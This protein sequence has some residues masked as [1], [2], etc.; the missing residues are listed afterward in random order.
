MVFMINKRTSLSFLLAFLSLISINGM[1]K[2][3]GQVSNLSNS[4]FSI[5]MYICLVVFFNFQ[6]KLTKT[7]HMSVIS[8]VFAF[9][10]SFFMISGTNIMSFD[11]TLLNDWKQWIKIIFGIPI[12]S[13]LLN[14]LFLWLIP[15]L[16]KVKMSARVES[17]LVKLFNIKYRFVFFWI[18]IFIAWVPGLI[19]SYPGI[20]G[21]DSVYQIAY[22]L[23]GKIILHHPL[24][25][26]YLLGEL[27]VNLGN[28]LG[29][30]ELGLFVYSLIQMGILSFS[31]AITMEYFSK[32]KLP[33][34][35]KFFSLLLFMFFPVNAIMAFSSTK[36]VI[37]SATFLLVEILLFK[38]V[39]KENLIY[40]RR[41]I[42]LYTV[43][44]FFNIIF[45]SQGVYVF[46]FSSVITLIIMHKQWKRI[47]LLSLLPLILFSIYSGP[48]TSMLHGIKEDSTHEMMSVPVM[49][50]SRAI[51]NNKKELTKKDVSNIKKY[52]PDFNYY[53]T[54]EG[55][56]DSMKNT[57][58]SKLFKKDPF[59]FTDLWISVGL[60]E[61]L[62]FVDAFARLTVG[63][64]YPDVNYRDT[65]AY[66]PYWEYNSTKQNIEK[67]FYIVGRKTPK[68]MEWLA[69]IYSKI[70]YGNSYQKI[71][72]VSMFFSS[73]I[74]TWVMLIF[75]AWS[76]Y[77]RL[78][79]FI[80]PVALVFALWLTL[81][82]GPVVLYRYVFPI[83]VT[84][85][86]LL[87]K[88]IEIE[89]I[90]NLKYKN[91]LR[92]KRIG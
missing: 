37:Y 72:V 70:T 9:V 2:V 74:Y 52:I 18:I 17:F 36:D 78:Y 57:F 11:S 85:P 61:P 84:V 69:N 90:D 21:Y 28:I 13:A 80:I 71:P 54:Y 22:F 66:H 82:L 6:W 10:F 14:T 33:V 19:A 49:Q 25:H 26:T 8:I 62:T 88:M 91:T 55:I 38:L 48:I 68:A 76:L 51:V 86:L 29:S 81:L 47:V 15:L 79:K 89:S 7:R 65:E 41:F 56:S 4:I 1:V 39:E 34:Y 60:K 64:W 53:T 46:I 92:R 35:L 43:A 30:R 87:F 45:R 63:L 23:S 42:F 40:N 59:N 58:N 67:T 83:A 20:Y 31:F 3:A 27:V 5:F 12:F 50:L 24:I 75:L 73:G 77:F 44:V 16:S 32:K